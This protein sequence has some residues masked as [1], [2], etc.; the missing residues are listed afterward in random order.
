MMYPRILLLSALSMM[1]LPAFSLT[2]PEAAVELQ[3]RAG[4]IAG[5]G[6][7]GGQ[8]PAYCTDGTTC[9]CGAYKVYGCDTKEKTA[10]CKSKGCGCV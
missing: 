8:L 10:T 1:F 2:L 7:S 6:S 9:K 4:T 3:R 5:C